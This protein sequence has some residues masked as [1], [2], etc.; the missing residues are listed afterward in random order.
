MRI[1][2]KVDTV[3]TPDIESDVEY[4]L[5]DI[6]ATQ[7]ALNHSLLSGFNFSLGY[8]LQYKG[9]DKVSGSRFERYRYQWMEDG[10]VQNMQSA[11]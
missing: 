5:G 3:V 4:D 8:S 7:I 9:Q 1:R 10:T 2:E 6:Y 11:T